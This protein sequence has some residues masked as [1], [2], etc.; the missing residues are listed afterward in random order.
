MSDVVQ[1]HA[2]E[3]T[4]TRD[5]IKPL[6]EISASKSQ[7]STSHDVV[8]LDIPDEALLLTTVGQL[9]EELHATKRQKVS[10]DGENRAKIKWI[11]EIM[12]RNRNFRE[13]FIRKEWELGPIHYLKGYS[14]SYHDTK[15][16]L[17][18]YFILESGNASEVILK[19]FE[20]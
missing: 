4:E 6:A 2:V 11:P 3:G 1:S 10:P 8:I 16:K 17:A 19:D 5:E 20:S 14:F 7:A 15:L 13:H 9:E 18:A 12:M